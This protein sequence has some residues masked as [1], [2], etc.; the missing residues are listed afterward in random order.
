M[1]QRNWTIIGHRIRPADLASSARRDAGF[2]WGWCIRE[3]T[4]HSPLQ[5]TALLSQHYHYFGYFL[6]QK[7]LHHRLRHQLVIVISVEVRVRLRIRL[8]D[9]DWVI[10][11]ATNNTTSRSRDQFSTTRGTSHYF[12]M[13]ESACSPY[14]CVLYYVFFIKFISAF[15]HVQYA[16]LD[17]LLVKVQYIWKYGCTSTS[18]CLHV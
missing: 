1:G 9:R 15:Y 14:C 3:P 4:A 7:N 13:A 2:P 8:R 5:S 11:D 6:G 16:W 10:S 18:T 12:D 17:S